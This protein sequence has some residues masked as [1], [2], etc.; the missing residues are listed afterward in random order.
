M[1]TAGM[2]SEVT[3]IGNKFEN[4]PLEKPIQI[5]VEPTGAK[6]TI[7]ENDF[8]DDSVKIP[9]FD[10]RDI[11]KAEL[12]YIP[13]DP[14]DKF[15]YI[16][17]EEDET[18][19]TLK[20]LE[21]GYTFGWSLEYANGYIWRFDG[22]FIRVDP[23][24][25]E[26]K[27]FHNDESVIMNPRGLTWDGEYFW[28][29]DFS[30]LRISK[31]TL[32]DESIKIL[33]TFDIPYK[34]NGGSNGLTSDDKYLYYNSRD[35]GILKLDKE[36]NIVDKLDFGGGP[37]VWT[38]KYFWIAGGCEKGICKYTRD[39]KLVGEIYP[40]A[41]DPWAI[42]WD[43]KHLWTRQRTCEMWNDAKIYQIQILN[44]SIN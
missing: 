7:S 3:V 36:G 1:I 35:R 38:G 8:G 39:G 28:V 24:T 22:N 32:E 13:G 20:K 9:T 29:N 40:P 30:L 14:E 43:G 34:E 5:D 25:G 12:G 2:E 19:K 17:A 4:V 44:N 41:K 42:T 31:F 23:D 21:K 37:L 16:Y 33:K 27:E 11:K 18:R 10:Y 6:F 15:P 26:R